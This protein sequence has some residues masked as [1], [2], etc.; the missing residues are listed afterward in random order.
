MLALLAAALSLQEETLRV[1]GAPFLVLGG[2][3]ELRALSPVKDATVSWRVADAPGGTLSSLETDPPFDSRTFSVRSSPALKLKSTGK[4]G[5]EALL[6]ASLERQG[7]RL[8]SVEHRLVLGPALRVRAW[9]RVVENGKGGTALPDRVRDSESRGRLEADVNVHLR[10]LGLEVALEAGAPVAAPDAWFDREGRFHPVV[11]KDGRKANAPVLDALLRHNEPGGL[12]LYLVRDCHWTTVE[13]GFRRTVTEHSLRGI[14]LKDGVVV[15]D[16]SADARSLAHEF[17][18]A[19]G[20][21]DL[22]DERER[23]RMMYSVR[24]LQTG[25]LFTYAE[26]K[27]ARERARQHLKAF[28]PRR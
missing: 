9:C 11:L 23:G 6:V 28:A 10:P 14:G 15:L 3:A 17:G 27:D 18:H 8:A 7:R 22:E 16:D 5:G 24:K 20:L 25:T 1:E 19:F 4:T 2:S 13:P 21:D 12:N 26:M